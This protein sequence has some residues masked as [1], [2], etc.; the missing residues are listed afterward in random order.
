[1]PCTHQGTCDDAPS[2]VGTNHA[3]SYAVLQGSSP[4]LESLLFSLKRTYIK[5]NNTSSMYGL[6]QEANP[7]QLYI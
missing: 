2:K 3:A 1:M 6:V 7:L 4:A 5:R